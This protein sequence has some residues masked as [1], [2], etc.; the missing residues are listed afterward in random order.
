MKSINP[1]ILIFDLDG[2]LIDSSASILAGFGAA[3]QA[4]EI[5]PKRAL[6][7]AIIGPPLRQTLS[8][9]SG[10]DDPV[11]LDSL[12]CAFKGY[13]DSKGYKATEAFAGIDSMLKAAHGRGIRL[14]IATNKRLLPTQL[15]L[16]HLGWSHLFAS[17]YALDMYAPAFPDKA[18]MLAGLLKEQQVAVASA[19][20]VG[21][22]PEDGF[23]AD[24]NGLA[25]YAA[26]WGY[27]A[28][29]PDDTSAHWITVAS[30][31]HLPCN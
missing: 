31:G 17:V 26:Q 1:E 19:A 29:P 12:A 27:S 4:H 23:A 2:T 18:A 11:L 16:D 13:Y 10:S 9:L 24:A 20:Y 8:I 15:I 25:F 5:E 7:A 22:R 6:T 14:H 28:F 21:D 3:L 30:P